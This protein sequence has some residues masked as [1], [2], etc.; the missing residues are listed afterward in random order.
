MR[1]VE[2]KLLACDLEGARALFPK[3]PD[4]RGAVTTAASLGL[5]DMIVQMY[6]C[7]NNS[8]NL[9][10]RND[11][12]NHALHLCIASPGYDKLLELYEVCPL[13][14]A[15]QTPA[16]YAENAE[17]LTTI[18]TKFPSI[19]NR[20]YDVVPEDQT[21][22]HRNRLRTTYVQPPEQCLHVNHVD[23]QG[24]TLLHWFADNPEML[25]VILSYRPAIIADCSGFYPVNLACRNYDAFVMMLKYAKSLCAD[26]SSWTWA[27][28]LQAYCARTPTYT[29]ETVLCLPTGR[30]FINLSCVVLHDMLT[31]ATPQSSKLHGNWLRMW[32]LSMNANLRREFVRYLVGY[33][34]RATREWVPEESITHNGPEFIMCNEFGDYRNLSA[35]KIGQI[36]ALVHVMLEPAF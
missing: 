22:W 29:S 12:G 36:S 23:Q 14:Q 32:K 5:C 11:L 21:K 30:S 4:Y 2:Q 34:E 18:L 1:S 9:D 6:A 3:S 33:D 28:G 20:L 25:A 26:D 19:H 35:D 27:D 24:M 31:H 13:N 17:Q 16:Y 8:L 10:E 7:R 15:L